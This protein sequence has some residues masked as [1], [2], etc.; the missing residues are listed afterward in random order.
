MFLLATIE[1]PIYKY[2]IWNINV[3]KSFSVSVL[4]ISETK[5]V[6]QNTN[7]LPLPTLII[8]KNTVQSIFP[9]I[10]ILQCNPTQRSKVAWHQNPIGAH[11]CCQVVCNWLVNVYT[12]IVEFVGYHNSGQ[13]L[14]GCNNFL[15]KEP[16]F[17]NKWSS[18]T[19]RPYQPQCKQLT[20]LEWHMYATNCHELFTVTFS[21]Y[22]ALLN[23]GVKPELTFNN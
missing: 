5:L 12:I 23:M 16:L 15:W 4:L 9:S 8:F 3:Q 1:N 19:C 22:I 7:I 20:V 2:T 17:D 6:F 11:S 21:V 18:M 10:V 13:K 14:F